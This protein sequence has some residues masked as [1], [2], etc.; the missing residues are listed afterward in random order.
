MK[1]LLEVRDNIIYLRDDLTQETVE[2]AI[3]AM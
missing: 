3:E 2:E 1:M